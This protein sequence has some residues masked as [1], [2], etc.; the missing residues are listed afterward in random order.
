MLGQ[1]RE[2]VVEEAD[3][4]G[5]L[6]LAGAVEVQLQVDLGF[7]RLAVNRGG[8]WHRRERALMGRKRRA[9]WLVAGLAALLNH[10]FAKRQTDVDLVVGADG[11]PQPVAPARIIHISHQ[12][13]C[14]F[15]LLVERLGPAGRDADSRRS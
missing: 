11:N 2:H 3:A 13:C 5:D 7:G 1:Q 15:E 14:C 10:R 4:G 9:G 6:G 8:A 12:D